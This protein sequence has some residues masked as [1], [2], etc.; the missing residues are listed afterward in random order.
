MILYIVGYD[1]RRPG[2]LT[3]PSI[4]ASPRYDKHDT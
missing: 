4:W 1:R 3:H 2:F